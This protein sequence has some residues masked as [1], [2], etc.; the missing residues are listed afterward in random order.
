M[1]VRNITS[2]AAITLTVCLS[3]AGQRAPFRKFARCGGFSIRRSGPYLAELG[4]GLRK[5]EVPGR[6]DSIGDPV[7]RIAAPHVRFHREEQICETG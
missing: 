7:V 1:R 5:I 4:F 3:G 6:A 2:A